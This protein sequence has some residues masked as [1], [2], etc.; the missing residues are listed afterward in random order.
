M[1]KRTQISFR[2]NGDVWPLIESWAGANG[3]L[4]RGSQDPGKLYQKGTG[5]L[6]APTMLSIR[7]ENGALTLEVWI[8]CNLF[9]RIMSLFILP[10]EMGI[11]SGGFKGVLPRK[12]ARDTVNGLL[13]Q[14][15][16]PLIP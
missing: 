4:H 10:A 3:F 9:T 8:Q 1:T 13:H 7:Q 16:Q 12:L 6:V 15:G 14:L 5:F 2:P 11:E